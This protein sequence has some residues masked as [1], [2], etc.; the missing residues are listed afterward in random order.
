MAAASAWSGS[1]GGGRG[2][3]LLPALGAAAGAPTAGDGERGRWTCRA[4]LGTPTLATA[5]AGPVPSAAGLAAGAGELARRAGAT[6]DQQLEAWPGVAPAARAATGV[7]T[8]TKLGGRI[9]V[10]CGPAAS[11]C[12]VARVGVAIDPA[13]GGGGTGGVA[14]CCARMTAVLTPLTGGAQDS[15]DC[16]G[17]SDH[18]AAATGTVAAGCSAVATVAG[19]TLA[20]AGVAPVAGVAAVY[21]W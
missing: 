4:C 1:G 8:A 2:G 17:W 19:A 21:G 7:A 15:C 5:L 12:S 16:S 11:A 13:S 9:G 20:T 6:R 10:V 14:G 3:P 18:D